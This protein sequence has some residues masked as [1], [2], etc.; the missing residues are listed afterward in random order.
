MKKM[1]KRQI[2]TILVTLLTIVLNVLANALPFNG[3][4]TGA[5]SDR[6]TILF[7]PAGYVFSIWGLIYIGLIAFTVFQALNSQREN[8]LLDQIA[9]AYW[10]AN[11]AN[12]VWLFLWHWE[13]FPLT[14]V[15]MI[16]ILASLLTLYLQFGKITLPL[17]TA[18]KWLVKVPFSI[19]LG[20]V[21][22]ASIANIS[23]V[24]FYLGWN[25]FGMSPVVWTVIMLAVAAL[26]GILML[27]REKN[28]SYAAVLIWAFIG[29][30]VKQAA[31]PTVLYTAW[32]AAGVVAAT[33][34]ITLGLKNRKFKKLLKL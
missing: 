22:V 27:L 12:N 30:A 33:G 1:T 19:Y 11:I 9:P 8:A 17:T 32:A 18:E 16:A 2:I 7:V 3:Q 13:Y 23:Q 20:W 6:F 31:T 10:V 28:F 14:L 4:G 25:G 26:L 21:S 34:L 29:I 5:I 15:V 24:L